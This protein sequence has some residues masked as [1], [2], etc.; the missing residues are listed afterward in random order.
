MSEELT[1]LLSDKHEEQDSIMPSSCAMDA[2][3]SVESPT[4]ENTL[5]TIEVP[6]SLKNH[7]SNL[8]LNDS[9]WE[10]QDD[11]ENV[12]SAYDLNGTSHSREKSDIVP[13]RPSR[14]S[15]VHE[16]SCEEIDLA[17]L[18][19]A[20]RNSLSFLDPCKCLPSRETSLVGM[21]YTPAPAKECCAWP[22]VV[23]ESPVLQCEPP[24]FPQRKPSMAAGC[25]LEPDVKET[26]CFAPRQRSS[27]YSMAELIK[28]LDFDDDLKDMMP[29][30]P[31]RMA[32]LADAVGQTPYSKA[33]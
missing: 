3:F 30:K 29:Y 24:A 27:K 4:H 20:R 6:P 13:F 7:F 33:A 8:S 32:S 17:P 23:E 31:A 5:F 18:Q 11:G 21:I 19:P 14:K 9:L 1:I 2:S 28:A 22:Q 10:I 26:F 25:D 16:I 15:S 12:G